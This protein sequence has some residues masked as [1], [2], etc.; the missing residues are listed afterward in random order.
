MIPIPIP[1]ITGLSDYFKDQIISTLSDV[2]D[3]VGHYFDNGVKPYLESLGNKFQYTKTFLHRLDNVNFYDIYFHI[4]LLGSSQS[5]I[6]TNDI[7]SLLGSRQYLTIIGTA[8]SGKSMLIKHIFLSS[9]KE[10][11]AVPIFI[12]LR[13]LNQHDGTLIEYINE[14]LLENRLSPNQK[15]LERILRK[16]K[17]LFLFDGYDEVYSSKKEKVTHEI[18][19]FIDVYR[20]NKFVITSRPGANIELL[21]RFSNMLVNDLSSSEIVEFIFQQLKS[22]KKEGFEEIANRMKIAINDKDNLPYK[23]YLKNPLLLSM[24][25]LTFENNPEIPKNR[26]RFYSNVFNALCF[27]HNALS[28][29]GFKHE[30]NL[31]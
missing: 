19:S 12:E 6:K 29:H 8:G 9:I 13:H 5:I 11:I 15:I 7:H 20:D 22:Y 3:E 1:D 4:N 30:K 10:K 27:Q 31:D 25:I 24:F 23:S 21:P 16:G 28:K 14:I 26:T 17:F 18:S 2:K